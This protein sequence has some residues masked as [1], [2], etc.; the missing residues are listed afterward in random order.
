MRRHIVY[1]GQIPLDTDLLN[2]SKNAYYGVGWLAESA[3]GTSTAVSGL[4]VTPTVPASLQVN[5]APGA[6]YS[7]QTVDSAAYGSLGTDSNQFVK[8]GISASSQTLTITPPATVGQSQNYLVQVAF[9]EVDAASLTLPYYNAADPSVAWSGPN[10]SGTAQNT[11][12][13]DNCVIQL[14]AGAPAPT[15][16]QTTPSPDVG[17]TGIYVITVANGQMTITSGNI[18]LLNS[19]PYFPTLGQIPAAIQYSQY[20]SAVDTGSATALVVTLSPPPAAYRKFLSFEVQVAN[21]A[22][23]P[24]TINVNG[25]GNVAVTDLNGAP[26]T[27]GFW[28][29]GNFL[30]MECD[31]TNVRVVGGNRSITAAFSVINPATQGLANNILA[32]VN[33]ATAGGSTSF[34]TYTSS[35]FTF[36]R[37]GSYFVSGSVTTS[38]TISGASNIASSVQLRQ[39]GGAVPGASS[40]DGNYAPGAT[41]TGATQYYGGIV[42]VAAGDV[43]SLYSSS[44]ASA[45]YSSSNVSNVLFA[46]TLIN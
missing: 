21:T 11:Q 1:P 35:N 20:N 9:A 10:N 2:T 42:N 13:Q 26:I 5:V 6:I 40:G 12:R 41:T 45:N 24:A 39:N 36:S 3:I 38:V 4:A 30:Q 25:L 23:G 14:K 22:T 7:L 46:I 18:A 43:L 17:F 31:G 44:G 15:G 8:Q 32:Q 33:F 34:G 27:P 37:A 29:A 16:S 19:A 28:Q